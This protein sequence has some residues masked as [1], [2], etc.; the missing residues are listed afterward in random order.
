MWPITA[1]QMPSAN[2]SCTNVAPVRQSSGN[3][4]N[5]FMIAPVASITTPAPAMN[6]ALS[7]WP[8]LNLPSRTVA[9]LRRRNQRRV[10]AGPAVERD[11][12]RRAGAC[13]GARRRASSSGT[14]K[15]EPGVHVH[16]AHQSRLPTRVDIG[17]GVE[18]GAGEHE[19]AEQRGV[20]P[21]QRA[22][23]AVEPQQ[24]RRR[25]VDGDARVVGRTSGGI[26]VPSVRARRPNR[27]RRSR[28]PPS[29]PPRRSL[30]QLDA[31]RATSATCSRTSAR[32]RAAPARRARRRAA[33]PSSS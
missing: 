27:R 23:D 9:A 20:H 7:F 6:A 17:P 31:R 13:R 29:S 28:A 19:H 2:Q 8:G 25:R 21:V 18:R 15:R 30:R 10:V 14:G 16:V 1:T 24:R 26:V 5:H 12:G 4:S 11:R 22:L 33:S 32:R 3:G